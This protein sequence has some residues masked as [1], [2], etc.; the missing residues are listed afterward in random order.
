MSYPA[1]T[2]KPMRHRHRA[3]VREMDANEYDR[4]ALTAD[5]LLDWECPRLFVIGTNSF[6]AIA[7]GIVVGYCLLEKMHT[8]D[9]SVASLIVEPYR[10]RCG[11]GSQMVRHLMGQS[12]LVD[13]DKRSRARCS[14]DA[15]AMRYALHCNSAR[16]R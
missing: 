4:Q 3:A 15:Q 14:T 7:D 11:I 2:I 10:R 9:L 5:Q 1:I 12:L 6:V 13:H 8:G 16:R